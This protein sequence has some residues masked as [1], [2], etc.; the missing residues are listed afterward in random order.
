MSPSSP[1]GGGVR[2]GGPATW[3]STGKW[4]QGVAGRWRQ[5]G[6]RFE[7]PGA[8]NLERF[9]LL[10]RG[11]LQA[12]I[13]KSRQRT[14]RHDAGFG[15][16]P[17]HGLNR[18]YRS[19]IEAR[20]AWWQ[21]ATLAPIGTYSR[22]TQKAGEAHVEPRWGDIQRDLRG[23]MG[24]LAASLYASLDHHLGG[25]A[26]DA[27]ANWPSKTGLSRAMLH[28]EI[29]PGMSGD[30]I[31]RASLVAGAGY[32]GYIKQGGF[33]VVRT[34]YVDK[35]GKQRVRRKHVYG[36]GDRMPSWKARYLVQMADGRWTFDSEAY[37]R[38]K[39]GGKF[40]GDPDYK[41]AK[42]KPYREL[43]TKPAPRTVKAIGR[44]AVDT[45]VK[46]AP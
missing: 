16:A 38:A 12:A 29:G 15:S 5:P 35:R 3:P 11:A 27:L 22:S 37:E 21:R 1:S 44:D 24:A 39:S 42:G 23:L 14:A 9:A 7:L 19:V 25:M 36:D 46:G 26:L 40:W 45:T 30:E 32:S 17:P 4:R 8:P 13:R 28:V 33:R 18:Q 41:P 31:M 10:Q 43:L 20:I 6:G 34:T 2:Q